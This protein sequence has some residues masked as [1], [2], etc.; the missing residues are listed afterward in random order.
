[1]NK[2][3]YWLAA[4]AFALGLAATFSTACGGGDKKE[5]AVPT[6][7]AA[8]TPSGTAAGGT[9][10]DAKLV[11]YNIVL[12][13]ASVPAGNVTFNVKN[14]GGTE[15][16]LVVLKTDSGP[17]A[18]PTKVDGSANEDAP[19]V[20]NVGET[21]DMAAGDS[22]VLTVVDLQPG[23]YVLIC[24][25]VQTTNGQTVSHYQRAMTIAFTVSQ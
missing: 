16:E 6:A 21:G 2:S 11:E 22:K 10:V 25:I 17:T 8:T 19:E 23:H 20:T 18:L 4:A 13:K 14:I 24:N 7:T 5:T 15:H 9:V 3:I 12:D 1:M